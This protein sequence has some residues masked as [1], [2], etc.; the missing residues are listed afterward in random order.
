M[1]EERVRELK[2]IIEDNDGHNAADGRFARAVDEMVR[3]VYDDIGEVS[4]LPAR[5]L[6]DLFVI[7]VLY[8]QRHSRHADVIDYLGALL[9]TFVDVRE[10]FPED[11]QGRPRQLYFSDMLDPERRPTGIDNVF[12]AYRKYADSALFLSGMFPE[13]AQRTRPSSPSVLRRETTPMVD[14]AYY[15]ST[16]KAMYRMAARDDHA[17][18]PHA[19]VTLGKLADHFEIYV[20]ALNE[21][22]ERYV[23]GFDMRLIADRMLDGYN[24]YRKSGDGKHLSQARRFAEILSVD[25]R[26]LG[27]TAG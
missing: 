16:G 9:T 10:L 8:V 15:V 6:F 1:I 11:E 2:T 3:A 13:R 18:C 4:C 23:M 5:T 19:A 27:E 25:P 17:A 22:S 7:K 12:D 20:D 26:R 14:T 21:M 24:A